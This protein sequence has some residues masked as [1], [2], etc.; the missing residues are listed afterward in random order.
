MYF[1]N[2][3][4]HSL[5]S[6]EMLCELKQYKKTLKSYLM[7]K[8]QILFKSLNVV[9]KVFLVVTEITGIQLQGCEKWSI[10]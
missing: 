5:V 4:I 3:L 2:I 1:S 10:M 7:N 9:N 8:F 6:Y